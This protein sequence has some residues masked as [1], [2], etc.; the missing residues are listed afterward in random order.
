LESRL[1]AHADVIPADQPT[2]GEAPSRAGDLIGPLVERVGE[3]GE[4]RSSIEKREQHAQLS[5]GESASLD[6]FQHAIKR[7]AC[8]ERRSIARSG[9]VL[10]RHA[11]IVDASRRQGNGY[12]RAF[13]VAMRTFF[14]SMHS[15][16]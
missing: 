5:G 8:G 13:A 1:V 16:S 11:P 2:H 9:D 12:Q 10:S 15:S 4:A 6:Q 3:I 7:C 14:A